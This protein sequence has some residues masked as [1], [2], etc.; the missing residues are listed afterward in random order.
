VTIVI[1]HVV[2]EDWQ[3][4]LFTIFL[5]LKLEVAVIAMRTKIFPR[6]VAMMSNFAIDR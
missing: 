5:K 1:F 2:G 4:E 3:K 6:D